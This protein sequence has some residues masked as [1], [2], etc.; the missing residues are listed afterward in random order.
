MALTRKNFQ[1]QGDPFS[2]SP[3]ETDNTLGAVN[4]IPSESVMITEDSNTMIT[5]GG[6]IMITE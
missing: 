1:F 6:D 4:P 5:E 3:L 2:N